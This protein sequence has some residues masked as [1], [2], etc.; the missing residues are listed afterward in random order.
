MTGN[1]LRRF[2]PA[3]TAR[4]GASGSQVEF[5]A[6]AQNWRDLFEQDISQLF[7]LALLITGDVAMAESAL[8]AS[9]D[10]LDAEMPAGHAA[11]LD[12]VKRAVMRSSVVLTRQTQELRTETPAPLPLELQPLLR[13]DPD[14]RCCFVLRI[15]SGYSNRDCALLLNL[16]AEDVET[17]VQTALMS[18]SY[19]P[20][21]ACA[22]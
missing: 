16:E 2:S 19:A 20:P 6:G 22:A 7:F 14:L 10:L 17:L 13:F 18:L 21:R 4:V 11:G 5:K 8:V 3:H 15:L 1:T 12:E 9:V